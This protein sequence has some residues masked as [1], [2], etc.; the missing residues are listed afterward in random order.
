MAVKGSLAGHKATRPF[1]SNRHYT[2]VNIFGAIMS[3]KAA[4]VKPDR[5]VQ[6]ISHS[7]DLPAYMLCVTLVSFMGLVV[8]IAGLMC[9]VDRQHKIRRA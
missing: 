6:V 8:A 2:A 7:N 3:H 1:Y 5:L 9:L 4:L